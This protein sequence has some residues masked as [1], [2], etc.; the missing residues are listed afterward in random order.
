MKSF[1]ILLLGLFP[2][3]TL[4]AERS[5]LMPLMAIP[6]KV[7]LRDDFSK[8][9]P[10]DKTDWL[11]RQGTRWRIE[12]GV[13]RGIP[14]SSEYQAKRSHHK[15]FEPRTSVPKTP[16]EFIAT[17][18]FRFLGGK[19]NAVVPFIE[20]GH[21]VCRVKFSTKEG[22]FILADSETL[23]VANGSGFKYL[24]GKWFHVLAEL[25]GEEFVIQFMDGPTLYAHHECFAKP[26][27]SGG[28]GLGVAGS[29]GGTVELDNVTIWSVREG[30]QNGWSDKRSSFPDFTPLP[31][32]KVKKI[33]PPPKS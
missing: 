27:S 29:H 10:V 3:F 32:G 13:L 5:T 33:T 8:D 22:A 14:S 21:H 1:T 9:G 23:R 2:F 18:S 4:A 20:F 28:H 26:N 25:K 31:T 17:F 11:S 7:A 30:Y 6:G 19:E 15:G 24:P 12:D 16:A